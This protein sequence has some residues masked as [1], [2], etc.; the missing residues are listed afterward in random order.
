MSVESHLMMRSDPDVGHCHL[1]DVGSTSFKQA[2]RS[3]FLLNLSGKSLTPM[4]PFT[5]ALSEMLST[6]VELSQPSPYR[7][8][9]D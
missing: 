4:Q 2:N 6:P 8:S 7:T 5:V 3:L 1:S 9:T